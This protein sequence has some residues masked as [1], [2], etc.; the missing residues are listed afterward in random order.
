MTEIN[1][2]TAILENRMDNVEDKIAGLHDM[3]KSIDSIATKVEGIAEL[4]TEIKEI[5]YN[6]KEL[7]V[8]NT[9]IQTIK[10]NLEGINNDVEEIKLQNQ[11]EDSRLDKLEQHQVLDAE[12][13][14]EKMKS[15]YTFW[16]AIAVGFLSF[17]ASILVLVLK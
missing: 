10:K 3:E 6:L 14:K 17:L 15:R 16:G 5:N 9:E 7:V 11:K 1:E 12:F 2:R 13:R 4:K 8:L